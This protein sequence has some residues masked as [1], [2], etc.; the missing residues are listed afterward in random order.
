MFVYLTTNLLNSKQY[1]G[2]TVADNKNYLGSG[3]LLLK[4]IK[5]YGKEIF[6]REILTECSSQEELDEQEIF[7]IDK[8]NTL[9]PNGYNLDL[10]GNGVGQH[11]DETRKKIKENHAYYHLGKKFSDDHKRKISERLKKYIQTKGHKKN[12][13]NALRGRNLSDEHKQKIRESI[14]NHW[15]YKRKRKRLNENPIN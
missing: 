15:K 5:K 9:K 4:T 2:Q 3:L 13:S 6:S 14:K 11:S 7:W 1:V 8:L 10:G 12:V